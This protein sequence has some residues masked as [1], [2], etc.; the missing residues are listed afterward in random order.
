MTNKEQMVGT[1]LPE[2]VIID[3]KKIEQVEQSDRST[4]L[5]KLLYRAVSEW[6]MDHFA[7]A[8]GQGK[9]TLSKAAEEAGVSVW[10]M[11]EYVREK[12]ISAQYSLEDLEHDLRDIYQKTEHHR[13]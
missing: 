9:M 6:K 5:R 13:A 2:S 8:Y 1:R 10:E 11:M 4:V 7:Q 3:L 12:K